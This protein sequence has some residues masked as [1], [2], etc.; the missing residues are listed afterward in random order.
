MLNIRQTQSD[1]MYHERLKTYF[2]ETY[3]KET[4]KMDDPLLLNLIAE[5]VESARGWGIES[6]DALVRYV[7]LAVLVDPKFHEQA[8]VHAF[9]EAP[10]FDPDYKVHL[11]SD[12]VIDEFRRS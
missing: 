4:A 10:G 7:G 11:L 6:S 12:L 3:P 8:Q 5:S 1:A 2:R 9:L